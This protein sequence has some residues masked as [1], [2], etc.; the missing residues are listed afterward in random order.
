MEWRDINKNDR[1]WLATSQS[2]S[3][4]FGQ[5]EGRAQGTRAD[6]HTVQLLSIEKPMQQDRT[7]SIRGSNCPAA[8]L[9]DESGAG[10]AETTDTDKTS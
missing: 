8:T 4:S 9:L 7:S 10:C 2:W 1:F 3:C 5:T 6:R